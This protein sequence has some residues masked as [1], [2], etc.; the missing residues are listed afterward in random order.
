MF[1]LDTHNCYS[2]GQQWTNAAEAQ[3]FG[4][5][6]STEDCSFHCWKITSCCDYY[7]LASA[8]IK[9]LLSFSNIQTDNIKHN[10]NKHKQYKHTRDLTAL[11]ENTTTNETTTPLDKDTARFAG[12]VTKAKLKF[13]SSLFRKTGHISHDPVYSQNELLLEE[14]ERQ[15]NAAPENKIKW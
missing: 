1:I 6:F 2:I 15:L 12:L 7:A 4:V 13:K 14:E 11:Q 9:L 5:L 8:E 10:N 3:Q